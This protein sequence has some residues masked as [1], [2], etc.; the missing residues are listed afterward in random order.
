MKILPLVFSLCFVLTAC[1]GSDGVTVM[2]TD[3]GDG[4]ENSG[5]PE[6][7]SQ[8]TD[9]DNTDGQTTD[10]QTT[11]GETTDGGNT[12][13]ETTENTD[14]GGV[15]TA[16][17]AT[18]R[19][20]FNASWSAETHPL[21]FPDN[22]HFSPLVG[23]VH[24]EQVELWTSGQPATDGIEQMAESGATDLLLGE[25]DA[26]IGN[27]Y[28]NLAVVGGGVA[29]SPG[30]VSIEFEVTSDYPQ[31]TLVSMV[32]PSPDWFVGVHNLSLL[33]NGEFV[34]ELI[35]DLAVYDAGTDS[36]TRYTSGDINN[37]VREPVGLL[38]SFPDD[39]PFLEGQPFVGQF[40]IEKL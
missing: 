30:A 1:S 25:V 38:N 17:S 20:T 34:A 15:A 37:D 40:I 2:E 5:T 8:N 22:P 7:N 27:G 12:D 28:A 16:G 18:Y 6:D 33:Q 24:N 26:A 19:L 3:S 31:L 4:A 13:G 32:A 14:N 21:L 35:V 36:G 23:A 29:T 10:G 9:G 39:S 11:D